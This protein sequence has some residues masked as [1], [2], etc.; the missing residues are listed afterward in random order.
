LRLITV[1]SIHNSGIKAAKMRNVSGDT[2]QA[3]HNNGPLAMAKNK[4]LKRFKKMV[5]VKVNVVGDARIKKFHKNKSLWKPIAQIIS[6]GKYKPCKP[7]TF[8]RHR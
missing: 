6:I 3:A 5:Y 2:G 1:D 8:Y 4:L 7:I